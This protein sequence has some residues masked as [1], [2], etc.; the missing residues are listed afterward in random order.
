[1]T[2][3]YEDL[4]LQVSNLNEL[5]KV[6]SNIKTHY[7]DLSASFNKSKAAVQ[8][9]YDD[10]SRKALQLEKAQEATEVLRNVFR[11]LSLVKRLEGLQLTL[12][13]DDRDK[14]SAASECIKA[15]LLVNQVEKISQKVNL[16]RIHVVQEKLKLVKE[17]KAQILKT[18]SGFLTRGIQNQ[19]HQYNRYG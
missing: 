5:D 12:T 11:V 4:L 8:D 17:A 10:I 1:M 7:E 9:P 6:I 19:V 18:A 16:E 15:A 14:S 2:E 13:D 3:H